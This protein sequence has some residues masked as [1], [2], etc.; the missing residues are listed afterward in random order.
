MTSPDHVLTPIEIPVTEA[1]LLAIP[2][3]YGGSGQEP[4]PSGAYIFRPAEQE[5]HFH[6]ISKV[7]QLKGELVEELWV[8]TEYNW[9][10]YIQRQYLTLHTDHQEVLYFENTILLKFQNF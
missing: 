6:E 10:S 4:Q 7:T 1:D 3:S 2:A 8:E 5:K 9:T